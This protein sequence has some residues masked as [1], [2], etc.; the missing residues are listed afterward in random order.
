MNVRPLFFRPQSLA[1]AALLA[2]TGVANAGGVSWS[3]GVNAPAYGP[4]HVQ[5]V[6]S[7]GPGYYYGPQPVVYVQQPPVYVQQR[8]YAPQPV[9][10]EAPPAP[11]CLPRLGLFRHWRHHERAEAYANG[12]QQ[13]HERGY[14]RGYDR[15]NDDDD[16]RGGWGRHDR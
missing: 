2:L 7:N 6:V 11:R 8:Y 5:A 13:G 15:G 3:V 1:A 10:Y 16:R 12:Y 4:G 9:V 14:E